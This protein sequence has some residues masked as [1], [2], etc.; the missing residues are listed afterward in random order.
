MG[1]N[2]LF[3]IGLATVALLYNPFFYKPLYWTVD[4]WGFEMVKQ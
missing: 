1:N 3:G 2:I 4:L